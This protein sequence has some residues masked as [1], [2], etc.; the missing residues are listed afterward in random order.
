VFNRVSECAYAVCGPDQTGPTP[1]PMSTP[2]PPPSTTVFAKV[3]TGTVALRCQFIEGDG[4]ILLARPLS[5]PAIEA[6]A[7]ERH[8]AAWVRPG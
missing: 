2:P 8:P 4:A 3:A 1:T 7:V 6:L 5:E